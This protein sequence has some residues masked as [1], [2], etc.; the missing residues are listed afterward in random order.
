MARKTKLKLCARCR[1]EARVGITESFYLLAGRT[2]KEQP[3]TLRKRQI[4]GSF[5]ARGLCA[6]CFLAVAKKRGMDSTVLKSLRQ[7]L[8]D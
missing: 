8:E 1:D 7:D 4:T 6:S 2:E 3:A 5:P